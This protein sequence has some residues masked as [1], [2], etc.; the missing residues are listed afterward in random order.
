MKYT[1]IEYDELEKYIKNSGFDEY[2][3]NKTILITGAKDRKSV[4]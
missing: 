1:S 2:L 3:K 4:V